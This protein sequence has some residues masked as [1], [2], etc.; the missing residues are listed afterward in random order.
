MDYIAIFVCMYL[1]CSY[2]VLA[3]D[4]NFKELIKDSLDGTFS[5]YNRII[6][7][8]EAIFLVF[9]I[10]SYITT[11]LPIALTS[12]VIASWLMIW[13][14][15]VDLETIYNNKRYQKLYINVTIIMYVSL[16]TNLTLKLIYE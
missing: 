9:T 13:I 1:L 8:I 7:M 16:L 3:F 12:L 4:D 14:M 10:V 2:V 11:S 5:L 6:A 15:F